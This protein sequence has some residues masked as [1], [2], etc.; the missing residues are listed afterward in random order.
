MSIL[1]SKTAAIGWIIEPCFII[2]LHVKDLELLKA[3][4]GFFKV[5]SVS[6]VN[7]K[8]AQ[9]R[10]RNRQ[11]LP[12]IIDHFN[13]YP[14]HTSKM[15]NF[16]YFCEILDLM[17]SKIHTKVNGFLKLISLIN[18]LNKP[19]KNSVLDKL[20][21]L[22]VLPVVQIE[23]PILNKN[24]ILNPNWISGFIVGE[25]CFTYFTRSRVN[26]KGNRVKD[27]TIV[28]EVSQDNKDLF[29]LNSIKDYF[30][31]GKVYT[32]T[33]GV[34]RFRLTSK[35]EIINTIVPY[36]EN[37]PLYGHKALQFSTWIQIVNILAMEQVRTT[38]RDNK[39]EKLIKDLSSL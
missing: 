10:V 8:F 32:D 1:K 16:A 20:A 17:G 3:I 37:Y 34:S 19:I 29:I 2:T 15:I 24:P 22:G 36:F 25:G 26:S 9:Y 7:G 21:Y 39:V 5:G 27:Y 11:E 18:K 6:I 13:K 33:R 31:V 12:V 38:D 14:L 23:L 30:K 28:M 35:D 4:H